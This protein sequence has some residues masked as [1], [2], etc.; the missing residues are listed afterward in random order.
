M[1]QLLE[2]W[3]RFITEAKVY[4]PEEVRS[5]FFPS[6]P[7]HVLGDMEREGFDDFLK[8]KAD[9][10][11]E[12]G[13]KKILTTDEYGK[14]WYDRYN[15]NWSPEPQILDLSWEDIDSKERKFL[16]DKYEGKNPNFPQADQKKR[17]AD[18]M[19]RFPG[20]GTGDHEPVIVKMKG[21]KI[22]DIIGG[23]HRTFVAFLKNDFEPIKLN[24]YV[25]T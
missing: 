2:N 4:T 12:Q 10:I 19:Q 17:Y 23:R 7:D 25:G 24:A 18:M 8:D 1:K 14:V 6:M 21:G 20:L 15:L 16:M 9:D 3:K 5:V 22:V 13:L 11:E